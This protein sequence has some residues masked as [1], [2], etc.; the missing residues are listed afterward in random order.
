MTKKGYKVVMTIGLRRNHGYGGNGVG[1]GG[2]SWVVPKS[3]CARMA[4]EREVVLMM[5]G[6]GPSFLKMAKESR[7]G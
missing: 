2:L 5:E 1:D 4:R 7:G 6:S 3:S